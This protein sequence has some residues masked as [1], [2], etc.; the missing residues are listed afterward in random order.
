MKNWF[1]ALVVIVFASCNPSPDNIIQGQ[2]TEPG[3]WVIKPGGKS[4]ELEQITYYQ[5]SP[6]WS[7]AVAWSDRRA[8]R[9]IKVALF[10]V[11]FV[12]FVALLVGKFSYAKWFPQFLDK[13]VLIFNALLFVTLSSSMYFYFGDASGI[14]WNNDK[15]ITK[16]LYDKNMSE[17]GDTK[18]IWDSLETNCLIVD[19]PY[20][21]YKK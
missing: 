15:W 11:L 12:L 5:I 3:N 9:I 1:L 7:Q 20:D 16:D 10:F 4:P 2:K 18:A 6:T 8:D 13:N 19:G 14:K 17:K 21:C